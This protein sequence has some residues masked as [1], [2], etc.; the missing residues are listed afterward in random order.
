[1]NDALRA[2]EA[3]VPALVDK[4]PHQRRERA[5]RAALIAVACCACA[6]LASFGPA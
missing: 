4:V 2:L 6:R 3:G 5:A 1:M